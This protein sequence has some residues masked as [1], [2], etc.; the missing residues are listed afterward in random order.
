MQHICSFAAL[1]CKSSAALLK[2]AFG[3]PDTRWDRNLPS[4][5][6]LVGMTR[7]YSSIFLRMGSLRGEIREERDTGPK[8]VLMPPDFYSIIH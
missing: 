8:H 6:V 3:G 1:C 2:R 4:E 7:L 5:S